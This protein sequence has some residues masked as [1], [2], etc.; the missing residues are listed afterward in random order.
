MELRRKDMMAE[1]ASAF[2]T[3]V[4]GIVRSVSASARDLEG[5]ARNM[6]QTASD[7][8]DRST[9]VAAAAEGSLDQRQCRRQFGRGTRLVRQRDQSPG[10]AVVGDVGSGR[11]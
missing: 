8:S 7:T 6:S 2:E 10:T 9:S 11:A 1:L 3:S 4:G 5:A